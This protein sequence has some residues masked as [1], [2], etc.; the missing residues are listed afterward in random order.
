MLAQLER[1]QLPLGPLQLFLRLAEPD[2]GPVGARRGLGGFGAGRGHAVLGL[3]HPL[4]GALHRPQVLDRDEDAGQRSVVAGGGR[5]AQPDGAGLARERPLPGFQLEPGAARGE[6]GQG[7][8][9]DLALAE[10]GPGPEGLGQLVGRPAAVEGE[11]GVVD[12][13]RLD[14]AGAERGRLGVLVEPGA[15]VGHPLAPARLEK[16]RDAG[17]VE[18][19]GRGRR[20][21][22]QRAV[23]QARVVQRRLV[24]PARGGDRGSLRGA[25]HQARQGARRQLVGRQVLD[26]RVAVGPGGEQRLHVAARDHQRHGRGPG[27]QPRQGRRRLAVEQPVLDDHEAVRGARHPLDRRLEPVHPGQRQ[28][29]RGQLFQRLLDQ[30]GETRIDGGEQHGKA[31]VRHG[32]SSVRRRGARAGP[33][34]SWCP[35]GRRA[36]G[37][38]RAGSARVRE[39]PP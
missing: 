1:V 26:L 24:Q 15:Q 31:R 20:V 14:L 23:A 3:A 5:D 17:E 27:P 34:G 8:G 29:E 12:R 7:G 28:V 25:A 13:D 10:R 19:P 38:N 32:T 11:G 18:L 2:L 16:A 6:L 30:E 39:S 35:G 22:Q 4:L 33:R 37:R 36:I 21:R 9:E